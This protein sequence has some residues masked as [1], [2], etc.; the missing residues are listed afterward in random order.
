MREYY[1]TACVF[2]ISGLTTHANV[3]SA[4]LIGHRTLDGG[5]ANNVTGLVAYYP[6]N[7]NANDESGNRYDGVVSGTTTLAADR[8]GNTGRAY[9]FDGNTNGGI[10]A[11]NTSNLNFTSGG[12][13][14][15]AWVCV[16]NY[17]DDSIIAGKH[18]YGYYNGYLIN[19][20][21]GCFAF[22]LNE[23]PRLVAEESCV[24]GQWH[25]VAG[26]WDGTTAYLYVDGVL[27]RSGPG[28]LRQFQQRQFHHRPRH[29]Y[30]PTRLVQRKNR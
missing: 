18:N 19:V 10:E 8:F 5:N 26:V 30:P 6:F 2:V 3:D 16:T 20:T 14:L 24:D 21:H 29:R 25:H 27:K 15:F 12:F 1:L 23:N 4:G 17:N 7:G 22:Y 28:K 13:S 9:H 11:P